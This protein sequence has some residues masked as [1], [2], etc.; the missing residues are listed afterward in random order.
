MATAS[1]CISPVSS[2][3]ADRYGPVFR[4]CGALRAVLTLV[5]APSQF[6]LVA[7]APA[8]A[9]CSA[10]IGLA[11][12]LPP[13]LAAAGRALASLSLVLRTVRISYSARCSGVAERFALSSPSSLL[14]LNSGWSPQPLPGLIA[15]PSLGWRPA[16]L[17]HWRR[18]DAPSLRSASF[19]FF[20]PCASRTAPGSLH[21]GFLYYK[22]FWRIRKG[23]IWAEWENQR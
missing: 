9:D 22:P 17:R 16:C 23:R 5:L 2:H 3:R 21:V 13:P 18:R 11:S 1:K 4:G 14:P 19:F 10:V 12:R 15:P 7:S 6:R 8:G 20:A